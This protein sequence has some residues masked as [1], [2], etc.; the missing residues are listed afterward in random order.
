MKKD[1]KIKAAI[2]FAELLNPLIRPVIDAWRCYK[3][4]RQA[5]KIIA[6]VKARFPGCEG[7]MNVWPPTS[8]VTT[9]YEVDGDLPTSIR[10]GT[11]GLLSVPSLTSVAVVMRMNEKELVDVTKLSNGTGIDNV[12]VRLK[13]GTQW[14]VTVRDN[15]ELTFPKIGGSVTIVDAQGS[16]GTLGFQYVAT[17]VENDYEAALKAPGERTLL[18]EKLTLIETASGSPQT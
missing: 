9:G 2:W 10:W 5:R 3:A 1:K 16:I 12:R 7:A 14:T 17:V 6:D 11:D 8:G 15:Q 18:V 13:Q 4:D